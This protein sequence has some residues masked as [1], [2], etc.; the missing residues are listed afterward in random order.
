MD[1]SFGCSECGPHILGGTRLKLPWKY[2]ICGKYQNVVGDIGP[3]RLYFNSLYG[4]ALLN[5]FVLFFQMNFGK[6]N[7]RVTFGAKRWRN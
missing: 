5:K 3:L 4:I 7:F 1:T 2:G 6:K